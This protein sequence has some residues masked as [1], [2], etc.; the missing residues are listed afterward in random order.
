LG[1][2]RP[3][4]FNGLPIID[5][6]CVAG[7]SLE[8]APGRAYARGM[9]LADKVAVITGGG[10][11]IGRATALLFARE[12]AAVVLAGRRGEPL[13]KTA[14]EITEAGGRA[15]A[16]VTDVAEP[17]QVERLFAEAE[18]LFGRIDILFNNAGVFV[19]GREGFDFSAEEWER[20]FRVNFWGTFHGMKYV[21]PYLKKAG[22]GVIINCSSVS[23]RVA[24]R[25]QAPYN[26]SKAAV[27][28]LSKCLSLE[29]GPSKIRINTI[30]PNMTE[31]DMA[32]PKIA[33]KRDVYES[34]YPLRRL[35][36]PE[37]IAQAALYLASGRSSWVSG[38]SLFV[39]GGTICL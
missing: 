23:G 36:Q 10:T 2:W 28:M 33:Q 27:E 7:N 9:D 34:S 30:C 13:A 39:D 37:D 26:T 6:T 4:R 18:K 11:G 12:G 15:G 19:G 24:Q 5:G 17:A 35:G 14:R 32:A 1:A 25:M 20:V 16:V 29:L 3:P 8:M 31:T 38:T 22:G 21:V